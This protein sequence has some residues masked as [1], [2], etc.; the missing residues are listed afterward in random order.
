M[1][2]IVLRVD[3]AFLTVAGVFGLVS[4]LQSY[5]SGSGPFGHTFTRTDRVGVV[6]AHGLA[7]LTAGTSRCHTGTPERRGNDWRPSKAD[8]ERQ[9]CG[10]QSACSI[11]VS[12]AVF[13]RIW[14][15]VRKVKSVKFFVFNNQQWF[16]SHPLRQS[17]IP[18]GLGVSG[19]FRRAA[20]RLQLVASGHESHS[21]PSPPTPPFIRSWRLAWIQARRDSLSARREGARIPPSSSGGAASRLR[22]AASGHE[23]TLVRS[24]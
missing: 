18:F 21:S 9:L 5:G 17:L 2:R 11:R 8:S 1:H 7:V 22:R 4:D 6:E 12:T 23:S 14:Q 16:E 19:G 20:T 3:A 10:S 13:V 24:R 15:I